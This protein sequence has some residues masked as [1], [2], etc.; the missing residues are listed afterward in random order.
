MELETV[1]A[2][3]PVST[4]ESRPTGMR[5]R[6]ML[7]SLVSLATG[8]GLAYW[9]EQARYEKF[10]G[11]LQARSRTVAAA[12]EAEVAEILVSPGSVIMAGEPIVRL[13]DRSLIQRLEVKR[14][15]VESLEIKLSQ[16]Q[17]KLEVELELRRIDLLDRLSEAKLKA[18][19]ASRKPGNSIAGL[20]S[21]LRGGWERSAQPVSDRRTKLAS[22][23][24]DSIKQA[25]A[26]IASAEEPT[27]ASPV[28]EYELCVQRI[29]ELERANRELP[30]KIGRMMGVD[31][32]QANLDH[33]K[34]DLAKLE[35]QQQELTLVAETSGTVGVFQKSVGEHVAPYEAIVQLLDEETP[36]L[37][38]Q[39]PSARV[40]DFEP[41]TKVELKFPGKVRCK[42]RVTEIPP[43]TTSIPNDSSEAGGT[44]ISVHV[45]P[46][47]ALWPSLPFGSTVEVKRAR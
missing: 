9:V 11:Y 22:T 41:G 29:Q 1:T 3:E 31:L 43:Q 6:V 2:S 18:A 39:I 36:Y 4:P 34:A 5:R 20:P 28:S 21:S 35:S 42:G 32:D 24:R 12:C 15:D 47:G 7:F 40:A 13:K 38:V 8:I 33:A 27:S 44:K 45:E 10:T 19:Q 30:G 14:R 26:T 16:S 17:A 37:M 25:G 23:N 46:S